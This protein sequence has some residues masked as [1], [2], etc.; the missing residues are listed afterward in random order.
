M[1]YYYA[2][3]DK[4]APEIAAAIEEQYLP[5]HAGD[6]LPPSTAGQALALEE[7]QEVLIAKVRRAQLRRA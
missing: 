7:L 1:G 2:L 6:R 5:R 4:E 3:N